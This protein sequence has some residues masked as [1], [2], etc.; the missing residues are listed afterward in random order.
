MD[1]TWANFAQLSWHQLLLQPIL[2]LAFFTVN[3]LSPVDFIWFMLQLTM[4][5]I[6]FGHF[7]SRLWNDFVSIVSSFW[8]VAR[9]NA[10]FNVLVL[11]PFDI[12]WVIL[13]FFWWII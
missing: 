5:E 12:L 7:F 6:T 13:Q 3:F 4:G 11:L 1:I 9:E 8:M 10:I 2:V